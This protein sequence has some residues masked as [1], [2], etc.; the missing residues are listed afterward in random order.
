MTNFNFS[1]KI[2]TPFYIS[3]YEIR[4]PPK[5]PNFRIKCAGSSNYRGTSFFSSAQKRA[6]NQ[7]KKGK[8]ILSENL[9]VDPN[10][11]FGGVYPR[12]VLPCFPVGGYSNFVLLR[13]VLYSSR[14][15]STNQT[16]Y[17]KQTQFRKPRNWPKLFI[18][19]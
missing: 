18:D 1:K 2:F 5:S 6:N 14:E 17:A 10:N 11:L 16:F 19:N 9:R 13:F 12:L 7:E 3:I 8:T 15:C 4:H